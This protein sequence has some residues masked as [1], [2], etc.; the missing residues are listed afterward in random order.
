MK[1]TYPMGSFL[2]VL[3]AVMFYY[4]VFLD[5]N[6]LQH[7]TITANASYTHVQICWK[8]DVYNKHLPAFDGWWLIFLACPLCLIICNAAVNWTCKLDTVCGCEEKR[9][10][11]TRYI[12][13]YYLI[14]ASLNVSYMS[15]PASNPPV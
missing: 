14:F 2:V 6:Q 11:E 8:K 3:L 12:F 1:K 4:E 7:V 13:E 5:E 10:K 15:M 9:K